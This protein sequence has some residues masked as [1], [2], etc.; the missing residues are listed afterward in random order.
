MNDMFKPIMLD[1]APEDYHLR[2][3]DRWGQLVFDTTDP[4]KGWDGSGINGGRTATGVYVWRLTYRP[5]YA[6]DKLDRFG[7]V[8]LLR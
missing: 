1:M 5:L 4:D 2:I 8:T 3:F 6:A 7:N